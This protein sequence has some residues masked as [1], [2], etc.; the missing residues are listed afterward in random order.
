MSDWTLRRDIR[1]PPPFRPSTPDLGWETGPWTMGETMHGLY[2]RPSSTGVRA[3]AILNGWEVS[4]WTELP[5]PVDPPLTSPW[6]RILAAPADSDIAAH[7]RHASPEVDW[8]EWPV[9][10]VLDGHLAYC[11]TSV[12]YQQ[13]A[14]L[15]ARIEAKASSVEI[16][17]V[18]GN[19]DTVK[20]R[21]ATTA[22]VDELWDI[23]ALIAAY[24]DVL[25]APLAEREA[26]ALLRHQHRPV[27]WY[28][29][30]PEDLAE[31]A[32][33][34]WGLIT[35]DNPAHTALEITRIA[36]VRPRSPQPVP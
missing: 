25:P 27:S 32:L 34:V 10:A 14:A 7:L 15:H 4:S 20:V 6:N 28:V 35:G 21:M 11:D 19:A 5:M 36:R 22:T 13:L 2:S 29:D 16:R 18:G 12:T 8:R 30:R 9:T 23:P 33:S 3:V 1:T 17:V 24:Q 26:E 31:V